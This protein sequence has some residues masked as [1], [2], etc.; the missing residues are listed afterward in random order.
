MSTKL[1]T[2]RSQVRTWA[3]TRD[4]AVPC[5]ENTAKAN[6]SS[7]AAE[8]ASLAAAVARFRW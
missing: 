8:A 3:G 7:R 5:P 6:R 2:P 4:W 1:W